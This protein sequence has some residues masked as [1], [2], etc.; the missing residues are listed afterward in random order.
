MDT[1]APYI[2]RFEVAQGLMYSQ[3]STVEVAFSA[4]DGSGGLLDWSLHEETVGVVQF[5]PE[6]FL[7]SGDP[8]TMEWTFQGEGSR[9]LILVVRDP[10][11]HTSDATANLVVDTQPPLL[12]LVLNGGKDITTVSDIPVAVSVMDVTTEVAKARIRVNSNEW[13]PWSDPGV[14][15]RVDLGPGEGER[16][17][18]VQAQ[19]MA[20]N[21][22]E[23]SDSVLVDTMV[24]TVS[25]SFTRTRPGGVVLGE[26]AIL[27]VF[28]EP[29]VT[30]SVGVVLMDNSS[31]IVDCA[32]E[33]TVSGTELQVDPEGSLQ[34][35]SHFVLQV[36]GEDMVGSQLD[37]PGVIFSTP[38]AESD[39][40]DAV[41]PG[42]SSLL[43]L[44]VAILVV[45]I[46]MMAY[47]MVRKKGER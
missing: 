34:R 13:G 19:D 47:G 26:S 23:A 40:W 8:R 39:D 10:A 17:V 1:T 3:T 2:T 44:V 31:G 27:L 15:R 6:R 37:F 20:G 32:L 38:E 41:L 18:F 33:W 35:G 12:T 36:S 9:T 4:E 28:S 5:D 25:V 29:M 14:F 46:I 45:G 7:A 42:D 16:T 43:L 22:A 11:G 21:L 30:G 24:P